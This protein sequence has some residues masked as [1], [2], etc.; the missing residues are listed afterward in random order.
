MM[1]CSRSRALGRSIRLSRAAVLLPD[2]VAGDA[3]LQM[4]LMAVNAVTAL[5]LCE[6]SLPTEDIPAGTATSLLVQVN[7][8]QAHG[9][10]W[11]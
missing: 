5:Q 1:S 6:D 3:E 4:E 2:Q 10:V 11:F 8:T 9:C 7:C